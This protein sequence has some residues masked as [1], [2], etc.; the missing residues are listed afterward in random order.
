MIYL[1]IL[2]ETAIN[3]YVYMYYIKCSMFNKESQI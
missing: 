1:M 3:T 2:K